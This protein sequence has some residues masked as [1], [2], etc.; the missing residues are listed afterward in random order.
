M[1]AAKAG[2]SAGSPDLAGISWKT[3]IPAKGDAV[4]RPA[5]LVGALSA[6]PRRTRESASGC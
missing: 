5:A 3:A 2:A 4:C 6:C 1:V